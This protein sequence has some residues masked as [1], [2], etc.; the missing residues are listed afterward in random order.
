MNR[1]ILRRLAPLFSIVAMLAM[2]PWTSA[3]AQADQRCFPE[4]GFCIAG[5]I[6][7]FWEQNGGLHGLRPARSH[8][9]RKSRSK[10]SRSRSSG[11]SATA[12]SC[13]RRTLGPYDVLLGR[14]GA[15]R[16]SPAG[17]RLVH[18]PASSA[19][20]WL[21]VLPRDWPHHLWR[22]PERL[23]REWPGV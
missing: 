19:Q 1:Q 23:A 9:S 2:L 6:R 22:Y 8:R 14:L 10:A 16:L 17:P 3:E 5:R 13:T 4:T 20:A 21:P 11:S 12:W 15:D 18:I 7:E